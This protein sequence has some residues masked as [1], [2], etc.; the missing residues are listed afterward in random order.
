M[1]WQK[2][3]DKGLPDLPP[4]E[5]KKFIIPRD[6]FE[7]EDD[8]EIEKHALPAFPDSAQQKGF[9]QT[10]IKSAVE[11]NEESSDRH[12]SQENR[13]FKTLEISDSPMAEKSAAHHIKEFPSFPMP[14]ASQ[15]SISS[16]Y[17]SEPET[18][19]QK[20]PKTGKTGEIFVKLDK[21]YSAKK[22]LESAKSKLLEI[23]EL[24][25]KIRENRMREEQELSFWEKEMSNIKIRIKEIS[26]GV[27]E[28]VE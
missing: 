12:E 28:K 6:D 24:L 2:K 26:E 13:T 21:F 22:S 11:E 17:L 15:H 20:A 3:E 9:S 14:P 8:E 27:F 18:I 1:F 25:K 23:D 7:D 4:I 10:A 5:P 19:I 16:P